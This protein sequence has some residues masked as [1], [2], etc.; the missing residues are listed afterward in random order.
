MDMRCSI[1]NKAHSTEL[2]ITNLVSNKGEWNNCFIKFSTLDKCFF[3][4]LMFVVRR[5]AKETIS[6]GSYGLHR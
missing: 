5:Q 6:G 2:A 3:H 4:P 1:A